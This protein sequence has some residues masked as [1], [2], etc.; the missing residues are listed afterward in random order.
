MITIDLTSLLSGGFGAV[1]VFLVGWMAKHTLDRLF[2]PRVLDWWAAKTK[3]RALRRAKK[4]ADI[5]EFEYFCYADFRLLLYRVDRKL[6]STLFVFIMI[7]LFISGLIITAIRHSS[8]INLAEILENLG[9][10]IP[11]LEWL[12]RLFL[13]LL[14]IIII[15]VGWL[16]FGRPT[17]DYDM[18]VRAEYRAARDL[19]RIDKL[20]IAAGLSESEQEVWKQENAK[21]VMAVSK[22][23]NAQENAKRI[24]AAARSLLKSSRLRSPDER[25]Q[26]DSKPDSAAR[27]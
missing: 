10:Y 3:A 1:L 8:G 5:L 21:I 25:N 7:F 19:G 17:L 24:I 16:E 20:L 27:G 22:Q 23:E 26:S 13:I 6:R 11:F 9:I 18:I 4:V 12:L 14:T 15:V 2:L